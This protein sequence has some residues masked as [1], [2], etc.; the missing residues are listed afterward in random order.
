MFWTFGLIFDNSFSLTYS[1]G[2]Q[3]SCPDETG[4]FLFAL[5]CKIYDRLI[6]RPNKTLQRFPL[7]AVFLTVLMGGDSVPSL[8]LVPVSELLT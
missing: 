8:A 6:G 3:H 1:F 7:V 4:L 5:Q 2:L